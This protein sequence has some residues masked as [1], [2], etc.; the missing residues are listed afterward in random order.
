MLKNLEEWVDEE[1]LGQ[2]YGQLGPIVK[3]SLKKIALPEKDNSQLLYYHLNEALGAGY[4]FIVSEI[5]TVDR[6]IG[7]K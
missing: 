5:R 1:Y 6:E 4:R 3:I 2:L 7:E